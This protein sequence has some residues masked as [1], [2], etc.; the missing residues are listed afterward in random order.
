MELQIWSL[1]DIRARQFGKLITYRTRDEAERAVWETLNAD[2]TSMHYRFAG[3]Y[4][5]EHIGFVDIQVGNISGV[6]DLRIDDREKPIEFWTIKESMPI[7]EEE[8]VSLRKR[9]KAWECRLNKHS[10]DLVDG[11]L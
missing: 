6:N 9:E 5:L 1:H 4:Q 10:D 3:D 2:R 11:K 7:T 8:E